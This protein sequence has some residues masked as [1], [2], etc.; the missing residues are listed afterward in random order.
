MAHN[1]LALELDRIQKRDKQQIKY[2]AIGYALATVFGFLTLAFLLISLENRYGARFA[3]FEAETKK[4]SQ[5][6]NE[7]F[8]QLKKDI[9]VQREDLRAQIEFQDATYRK[10][11]ASLQDA[12]Q[13][14]MEEI[15]KLWKSAYVKSM[16]NEE[17]ISNLEENLVQIDDSFKEEKSKTNEALNS[18]TEQVRQYIEKTETVLAF[19]S[20]ANAQWVINK[21]SLENFEAEM[22]LLK[23]T[24]VQLKDSL[25]SVRS[26]LDSTRSVTAH[27]VD[28][29]AVEPNT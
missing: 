25:E 28:S 17:S 2:L 20:D 9:A 24:T 11:N 23:E 13:E 5:E 1:P 7:D 27:Q 22:V 6:T 3:E 8:L 16:K 12:D 26:E 19:I 15:K 29:M 4:L 14:F 21:A 10:I 18:L